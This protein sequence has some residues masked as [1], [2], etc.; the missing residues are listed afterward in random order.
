MIA[1]VGIDTSGGCV[2]DE[3]KFANF[4]SDLSFCRLSIDYSFL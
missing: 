2:T 4:F 1:K 3:M